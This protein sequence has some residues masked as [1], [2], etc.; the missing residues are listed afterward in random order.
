MVPALDI[1]SGRTDRKLT[2][3]NGLRHRVDAP[4][5]TK[6]DPPHP[7]GQGPISQRSKQWRAI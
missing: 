6:E 1:N 4:A 7:I 5:Q 2:D 3:A